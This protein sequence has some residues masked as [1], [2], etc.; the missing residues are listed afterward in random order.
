M[1]DIVLKDI[2]CIDDYE[3]I[4]LI[5]YDFNNICYYTIYITRFT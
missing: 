3:E 1:I 2:S 4:A 5:H